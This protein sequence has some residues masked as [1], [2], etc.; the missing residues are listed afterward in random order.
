MCKKV[1]FRRLDISILTTFEYRY[2]NNII[3]MQYKVDVQLIVLYRKIPKIDF[4]T[5]KKLEFRNNYKLLC[6]PL[7]EYRLKCQP[8]IT[9]FKKMSLKFPKIVQKHKFR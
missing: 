2:Q 4:L 8:Y 1:K 6:V 5:W 9:I 3:K 7:E